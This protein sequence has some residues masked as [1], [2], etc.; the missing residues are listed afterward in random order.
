MYVK[1]FIAVI[2]GSI[3]MSLFILGYCM[4]FS[5]LGFHIF[6]GNL[7]GTTNFSTL[8]ES[9]WSM[10][11]LLT[12]TNFPDVM[13]PAYQEN[14]YMSFF[15]IIYLVFGLFLFFNLLMAIF[16]SSYQDSTG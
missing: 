7:E 9:F 11:V 5:W 15:F 6:K 10:F 8:S 14:K 13:L 4:Y 3:T 1:R 2:K 12:T 16:Y